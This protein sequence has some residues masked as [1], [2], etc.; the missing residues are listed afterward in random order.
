MLGKYS[1][2]TDKEDYSAQR[3]SVCYF[4]FHQVAKMVC[5]RYKYQVTYNCEYDCKMNIPII[6]ISCYAVF[7][8]QGHNATERCKYA[9]YKR[10]VAELLVVKVILGK[11]ILGSRR[12]VCLCNIAQ[13]EDA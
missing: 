6:R 5:I 11:L 13:H 3:I 4:F 10:T 8:I 9:K 2:I 1:I 12:S 7:V